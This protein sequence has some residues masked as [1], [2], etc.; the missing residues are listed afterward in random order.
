MKRLNFHGYMIKNGIK[1]LSVYAF[2]TDNFKR[3]KEEDGALMI[4]LQ[5]YLADCENISVF[6]KDFD[7]SFLKRI[8]AYDNEGRDFDISMNF[9]ILSKNRYISDG[10]ID[11]IVIPNEQQ[12]QQENL[13]IC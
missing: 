5:K 9:D 1:V 7:A 8:R 13:I 11:K 4:L 12:K 3:S 2:S 6:D 10:D